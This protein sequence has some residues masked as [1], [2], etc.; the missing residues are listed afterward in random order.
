MAMK[1]SLPLSQLKFLKQF[2]YKPDQRLFFHIYNKIQIEVSNPSF[3][4][5]LQNNQ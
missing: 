2:V 3:C 5:K 4:N 1:K